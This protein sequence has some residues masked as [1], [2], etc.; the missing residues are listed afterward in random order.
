MLLA[1]TEVPLWLTCAF[2]AEVTCWPGANAQVNFQLVTWGPELMTVTC[3]VKPPAHSLFVHE[4]WHAALPA[5]QAGRWPN[6]AS[7][8]RTTASAVSRANA[9]PRPRR[10]PYAHAPLRTMPNFT[11]SL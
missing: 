7:S 3:A 11:E 10:P 1:A 4:T 2:Q 8:P 6:P 9:A 5:P